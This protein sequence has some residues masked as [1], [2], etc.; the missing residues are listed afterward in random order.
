M[1]RFALRKETALYKNNLLLLLIMF[2]CNTDLRISSSSGTSGRLAVE[3]GAKNA[4]AS[5][6]GSLSLSMSSPL[7]LTATT[8]HFLIKQQHKLR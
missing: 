3:S 5:A 6:L 2:C 7:S 8:V 4:V 1:K